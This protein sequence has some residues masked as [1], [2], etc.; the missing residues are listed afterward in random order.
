MAKWVAAAA[1]SAALVGQA[2]AFVAPAA[3]LAEQGTALRGAG[4]AGIAAPA[5]PASSAASY[6]CA[7]FASAVGVAAVAANRGARTSIRSRAQRVVS[8]SAAKVG[9]NIPAVNL[10]DGF[11]PKPFPLADYCKGKK[12]ILVGLPGAFTPT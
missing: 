4:I 8:C 9:D 2:N 12:V 3:P 10:D 5:S 11:P 7:A 1:A 6:G